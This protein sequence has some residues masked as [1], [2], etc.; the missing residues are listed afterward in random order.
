MDA[1]VR[2]MT[3]GTAFLMVGAT[4]A[5]AG[6]MR[7]ASG[8]LVKVF[9]L[10]GAVR[11]VGWQKS[12]VQVR[13]EG[14]VRIDRRGS[15]VHITGASPAG[16]IEGEGPVTIQVP[17]GARVKIRTVSGAVTAERLRGPVHLRT[18]SGDIGVQGCR[19]DLRLRSVGGAVR[20][21]DSTGDLRLSSVSGDVRVVGGSAGRLRATTVSGGIHLDGVAVDRA[22]LRTLSGAVVV[23]AAKVS[24]GLRV[25]TFSGDADVT[26]PRD[27]GVVVDAKT[28]SGEVYL[29]PSSGDGRGAPGRVV[30]TLGRGG[31]RLR[32]RSFSGTLRV[33]A[34]R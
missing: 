11:A 9:L 33:R 26:W 12:Q 28:R 13:P 24:T 18:I 1:Q 31:S 34:S 14:A 29:G 30:E 10:N 15:D 25:K 32:F 27:T 6:C 22:Q 8:P 4:L 19:G 21:R 16:G 2:A 17:P 23:D 5:G 3:W 7:G 20:V